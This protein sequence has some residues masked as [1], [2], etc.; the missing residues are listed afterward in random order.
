MCV[1]RLVVRVMTVDW[2]GPHQ[3]SLLV[4]CPSG[5]KIFVTSTVHVEW[6]HGC[7]ILKLAFIQILIIRLLWSYVSK[8]FKFFRYWHL[9]LLF[10]IL[11]PRVAVRFLLT[12]DLEV[13]DLF[14][15]S[16]LE[17]LGFPCSSC[18]LLLFNLHHQICSFNSVFFSFLVPSPLV[19]LSLA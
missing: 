19:H 4:T 10:K 18:V 2:W 14:V 3:W 11:W 6:R 5:H 13:F 12:I 16:L 17:L 8:E 9:L 15:L 1:W 7:R